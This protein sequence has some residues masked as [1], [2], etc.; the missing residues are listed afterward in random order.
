M[1]WTAALLKFLKL[2][3]GFS[4]FLLIT[5]SAVRLYGKAQG[6]ARMDHDVLR[7]MSDIVYLSHNSDGSVV[8]S[9]D[10]SLPQRLTKTQ[11]IE[12][13]AEG[14][15]YT[16]D[17]T[18]ECFFLS[19]GFDTPRSDFYDE[20]IAPLMD[21]DC[22]FIETPYMNA[23]NYFSKEK[24]RWF[25]NVRPSQ[26]FQFIFFNSLGLESAAPLKGD[27]LV[28]D[29]SLDQFSSRAI[30]EVIHRKLVIFVKDLK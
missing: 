1:T 14:D 16:A 23:R 5:H 10:Q 28:L 15:T 12:L 13:K 3:I 21:Q 17:S 4:A 26:W 7:S 9:K 25:Y 27:F 20:I 22:V 18:A 29:Q 8:F 24:P 6:H 2:V 19:L 11:F 30:D